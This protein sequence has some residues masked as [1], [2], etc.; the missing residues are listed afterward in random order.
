ML[1][2]RNAM[3]IDWSSEVYKFHSITF[4]SLNWHK[5]ICFN[6]LVACV[7]SEWMKLV[8]LLSCASRPQCHYWQQTKV[9]WDSS[10]CISHSGTGPLIYF[11]NTLQYYI[12]VG[13]SW[14]STF[15]WKKIWWDV[16]HFVRP[17][18]FFSC[19]KRIYF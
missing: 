19:N 4:F 16:C 9:Q 18:K 2:V 13:S 7:A 5:G 12:H 14:C 17:S 11:V 1:V 10:Y 6:L 15:K 3:L 8:K